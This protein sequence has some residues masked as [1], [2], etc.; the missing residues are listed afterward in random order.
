MRVRRRRK[1]TG[2][3]FDL[4]SSQGEGKSRAT[5]FALFAMT[6]AFSAAILFALDPQ[7]AVDSSNAHPSSALDTQATGHAGSTSRYG[8]TRN[9]YAVPRR[10]LGIYDVAIKRCGRH[11][12]TC[13]VDGDTFWL[14]GEKIRIADIDTPEVHQPTCRQE[15]RLGLMATERLIELLN[16]G[17]FALLSSESGDVDKYGRKLRV[18]V[19][20]G[21]SIGEQLVHEGLA[22]HWTGR[23]RSWC[24]APG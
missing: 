12:Y 17:E 7:R 19:R 21:N 10:Q 24:P 11:R 22:Q 18:I 23:K 2:L 14:N 16:Q 5:L 15:L 13:V 20:E 9:S 8:D 3:R 6:A 1:K 4:S